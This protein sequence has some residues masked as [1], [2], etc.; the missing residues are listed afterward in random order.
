MELV[1]LELPERHHKK[2]EN[3]VA[4]LE[5][6]K[7]IRWHVVISSMCEHYAAPV[8]VF[9]IHGG[10]PQKGIYLPNPHSSRSIWTSQMD[11]TTTMAQHAQVG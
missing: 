3:A 6:Q 4:V 7:Q 5:I 1:K 9:T 8:E 10:E 2:I 11:R